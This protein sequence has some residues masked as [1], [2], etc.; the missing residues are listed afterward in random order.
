MHWHYVH[1]IVEFGGIAQ[2][3]E[4][5]F[6]VRL[7][8][9]IHYET[10]LLRHEPQLMAIFNTSK[11]SHAS[12]HPGKAG[13]CKQSLEL[14]FCDIRLYFCHIRLYV[15]LIR[16]YVSLIGLY[17]FLIGL[18]L[19]LVGLYFCLLGCI[20]ASLG[21]IC[22]WLGFICVSL[23]LSCIWKSRIDHGTTV[24]NSLINW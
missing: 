15:S 16:K 23:L 8:W 11:Q 13:S 1:K 14:Y 12:L 18:N 6:C 3:D 17:L 21:C 9:N 2:D 4:L 20:C 22:P 10:I 7:L 24:G 5:S 19:C